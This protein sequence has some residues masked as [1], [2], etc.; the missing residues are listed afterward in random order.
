M[1]RYPVALYVH[2]PFCASRCPYCDYMVSVGSLDVVPSFVDLTLQRIERHIESVGG[3]ASLGYVGG[4][5]PS[6]LPAD[7]LRRLVAAVASSCVAGSEVTVEL[8]PEHVSPPLLALCAAAGAT[9]ISVGGQ[10]LQ[11]QLLHRLGRAADGG[12]VA[13]ALD[14]LTTWC[15]STN[16]DVLAGVPGQTSTDLLET[17]RQVGDATDHVTLLDLAGEGSRAA[18]HQDEVDLWLEGVGWLRKAGFDQYE[19]VHFGRGWSRSQYVVHTATLDPLVA[20]GPGAQGLL[21]AEHPARGSTV[22]RTRYPVSL[23]AYLHAAGGGLHHEPVDART[24]AVDALVGGLRLATG[25]NRDTWRRRFGAEAEASLDS[26]VA[27]WQRHGLAVAD[28]ES[29]Q[30][31]ADGALRSDGLA[32]DAAAAVGEALADLVLLVWP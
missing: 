29:W 25:I 7:Q 5:T 26:I 23:T 1:T 16:V 11:T 19:T 18:H 22:V 10:A 20:V 17:L 15:G 31:T 4:G 8:N 24:M 3:I 32:A 30:L 6:L 12:Q 2:V 9:R 27:G 13:G 14:A 28:E 21:P